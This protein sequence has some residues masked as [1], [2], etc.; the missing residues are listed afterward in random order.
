MEYIMEY[1]VEI[2]LGIFVVLGSIIGAQIAS[3]AALKRVPSQ[4]S[5]DEQKATHIAIET[6]KL[7][8]EPLTKKIEELEERVVN[9]KLEF[10]RQVEEMNGLYHI[11]IDLVVGRSPSAIITDVKKMKEANIV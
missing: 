3:K 5:L 6:M 7:V 11:E 10:D 9:N 8:H 2:I 4:N 1:I